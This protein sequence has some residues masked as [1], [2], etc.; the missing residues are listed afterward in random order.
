MSILPEG[1]QIWTRSF[2]GFSPEEDGYVGW[3]KAS[4][5][6]RYAARLN[7]GDLILIYGAASAETSKSERSYVLGFV[8]VDTNSIHDHEKSSEV[9]MTK[10]RESGYEGKWS[11]AI[12][13]RRAWRAEEKVMISRIAFNSYRPEAGQSLATHGTD[14]DPDEILQALKIRVRE[15]SVFGEP[16]VPEADVKVQPFAEVF[17]PSRAFPSSAGERA[18]LYEDG[19]TYL[20]LAEFTGDGHALLG[21]K[22]AFGDN[23]ALLKIGVSNDPTRRRDELNQGFPPAATRKWEIRLNSQAFPNKN[24]A[25]DVEAL[26]KERSTAR[27]ESLGGEFFWGSRDNAEI[28]CWSLPGMSRF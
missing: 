5:R 7:D 15:V 23:S 16:S 21:R 8:Q 24:A 25:E 1:T 19:D 18:S 3:S 20:Y 6:D 10:K 4:A 26:F 9:G 12:P 28:L 22:K 14:L 11:K 13:V 2:Y 17:K 27:L